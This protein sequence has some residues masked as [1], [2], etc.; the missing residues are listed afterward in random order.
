MNLLDINFNGWGNF[1]YPGD[2][3]IIFYVLYVY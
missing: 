1:Y 3:N 2:F